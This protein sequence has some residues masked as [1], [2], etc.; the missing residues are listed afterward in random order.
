MLSRVQ[1][2]SSLPTKL[3]KAPAARKRNPWLGGDWCCFDVNR[4]TDSWRTVKSAPC[5]ALNLDVV[6]VSKQVRHVNP[7]DLMVLRVVLWDT[8]N[9]DRDAALLEAAKV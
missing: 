8:V 7:I 1:D 3:L 9:H 4:S 6:R 5:S 2:G